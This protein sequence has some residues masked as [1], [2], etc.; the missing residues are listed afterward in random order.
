MQN[1]I[2]L[3]DQDSHLYTF[4]ATVLACLETESGH[5]RVALDRTAFFP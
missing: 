3:F 2:R 1:T 4:S 5:F